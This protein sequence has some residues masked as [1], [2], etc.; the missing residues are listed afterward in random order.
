MT[1]ASFRISCTAGPLGGSGSF[2]SP[3][4]P[5]VAGDQANGH[6]DEDQRKFLAGLESSVRREARAK[7]ATGQGRD[8]RGKPLR[9]QLQRTP[10]PTQQAPW[11][12]HRLRQSPTWVSPR[13]PVLVCVRA[14]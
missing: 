10:T 13:T 2:P 12:V 9:H 5:E 3:E 14:A 11:E 7:K 6:L 4:G 1:S 8:T